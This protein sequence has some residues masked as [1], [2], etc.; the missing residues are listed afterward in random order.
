MMGN[1][2]IYV[3]KK[4]GFQTEKDAL[5]IDLNENLHLNL[6][7]IRLLNSYDI[8]NVSKVELE[9]IKNTVLSEAVTDHV[10]DEIQL[11]KSYLGIEFLPGQYDLRQDAAQ[12]CIHLLIENPDIV[13]K[14]SSLILFNDDVDVDKIKKYLINPIEKREKDMLAPLTLVQDFDI[15]PLENEV[16]LKNATI[17]ELTD[18]LVNKRLA[19]NISDL[20]FIQSHYRDIEKRNPTEVDAPPNGSISVG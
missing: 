5:L 20:L 14:T 7:Q 1:F 16:Q 9:I 4:I 13:V 15:M 18:L 2:R 3:E 10:Y 6:K 12:Q 11:T 8:F 17:N 19:M